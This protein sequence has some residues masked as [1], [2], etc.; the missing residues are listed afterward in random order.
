M[1]TIEY[2]VNKLQYNDIIINSSPS[3]YEDVLKTETRKALLNIMREVL[4]ET[5][6]RVVVKTHG[7]D[8]SRPMNMEEIAENWREV[9]GKLPVECYAINCPRSTKKKGGYNVPVPVKERRCHS[10]KRFRGARR[11]DKCTSS[12]VSSKVRK[13]LSKLE[14]YKHREEFKELESVWMEHTLI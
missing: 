7:L 4:S 13:A 3:P 5:E 12:N 1:N 2:I 11:A 8:G 14:R 9:A 10:C 6:F